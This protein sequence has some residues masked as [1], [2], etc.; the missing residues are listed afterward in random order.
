M[1]VRVRI[2]SSLVATRLASSSFDT[3]RSGRYRPVPAMRLGMR[4]QRTGS[5]VPSRSR[6]R[7][8]RDALRDLFEDAV[9][10]LGRRAL[11][12]IG[13]RKRVGAAMTLYDDA[14]QADE[15]RPIE[16]PRIDP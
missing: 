16:P 6:T 14:F 15:R 10:D 1:P 11:Q 12:R 13:E 7:H 4:S 5:I 2:H 3:T 9:L 8:F